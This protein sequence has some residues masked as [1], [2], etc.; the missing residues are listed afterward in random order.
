VNELVFSEEYIPW[1]VSQGYTELRLD[2]L[3]AMPTI[4]E[5]QTADLKIETE[6]ERVWLE[7]TGVSDG[8]WCNDK[9]TVEFLLNGNW[10]TIVEYEAK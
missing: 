4:S 2:D 3:E 9:V 1:A 6:D 10:C 5:S 7:R 8:E